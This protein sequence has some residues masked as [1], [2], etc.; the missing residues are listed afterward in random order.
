MGAGRIVQMNTRKPFDLSSMGLHLI[1]MLLMLCDHLWATVIS[2]NDWLTCLGRLAFPIF[3]F[4]IVEGYFHT[5]NLKRYVLRLLLFAFISEIPFNLMC[6]GSLIYPFHQNVMWTFLLGLAAVH[7]NELARHSEKLWLCIVAAIGTLLVGYILGF[8]TMV[9][10]YGVGVITVLVFY[11]FR[12][13]KWWCLAGQIVALYYLNV[14]MLGGLSYEVSILGRDILIV[15]QGLTLLALI[16]IWLYRGRQGPHSKAFQ[17][18]CYA[19][20]PVHMAILYFIGV[21]V[22]N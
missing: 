5:K 2:G 7:L 4:M 10:Y 11:F 18:A 1:A 21:F 19:F 17:Y 3:A 15:Q 14:E 13:R 6:S 22:V 20:Y 8:L 9:D 16:P 12:G